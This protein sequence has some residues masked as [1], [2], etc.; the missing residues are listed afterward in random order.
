MHVPET[1]FDSLGGDHV[2]DV[3]NV[4]FRLIQEASLTDEPANDTF[5]RSSDGFA[6]G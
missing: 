2:T 3:R 6:R 5:R 1:G 4:V